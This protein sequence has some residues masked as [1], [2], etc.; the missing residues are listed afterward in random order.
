MGV[1]ANAVA[2]NVYECF[3]TTNKVTILWLRRFAVLI[4]PKATEELDVSFF[5]RVARNLT[6]STNYNRSERN[7][8]CVAI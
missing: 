3:I 4:R 1:G 2:Q 5:P 8:L 6:S 7:P